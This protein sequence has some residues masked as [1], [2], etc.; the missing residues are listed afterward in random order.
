MAKKPKSEP[1]RPTT[2]GN[3]WH[4]R[5]TDDGALQ[6]LSDQWGGRVFGFEE[7]DRV[8]LGQ[9]PDLALGVVAVGGGGCGVTRPLKD[10]YKYHLRNEAMEAD[11]SD[12]SA[13][14][15][16]VGHLDILDHRNHALP[17]MIGFSEPVASTL[18][19]DVL[20]DSPL[21]ERVRN[22]VAQAREALKPWKKT[23]FVDR[24]SLS[25][26]EGAP[27]TSETTAD[28]HYAAIGNGLRLDLTEATGQAGLPMIVVSQ[29]AGTRDDGRSEV[30][31][32]EG[33]LHWN[34]FSLGFV[35]ATPKYPFKLMQG[36]V[37]TLD[38]SSA[39]LVSELEARA[40]DARQHGKDWHCPSLEEAR[41]SGKEIKV[42]FATM[43]DLVLE[44]GPHGFAVSDG[45]IAKVWVEGEYVYLK[46]AHT[47]KSDITLTYAW[48]ATE[49][50]GGLFVA[51]HGALRDSWS[52]PSR[53]VK[54]ATLHRYALSGRVKA[55]RV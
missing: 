43:S 34:H 21:R 35:V 55:R 50:R 17:T 52:E 28:F 15:Q 13:E 27:D 33:R 23:L 44:D 8:T 46:L 9:S 36:T 53:L 11:E 20:P 37:G 42:R 3:V 7:R 16:A 51:N 41:I 32:A 30:I 25:L 5:E 18:E 4:L 10:R 29:G 26:L 45:E 22:R 31:L 49:E 1:R 47:P 24:I 2:N 19:A 48:G 12:L 40:I 39:L 54:G 38:P 6:Y 14:A